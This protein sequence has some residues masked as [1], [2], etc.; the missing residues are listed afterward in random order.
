LQIRDILALA[1]LA[2]AL[3]A[4][5][6]CGARSTTIDGYGDGSD[7]DDGGTTTG[8]T[9]STST[10]S[11]NSTTWTNT[12]TTSTT[13]TN[14]V[15]PTGASCE[16]TTFDCNSCQECAINGPCSDEVYDCSDNPACSALLGCVNDCDAVCSSDPD[17]DSCFE[18]CV[19]GPGG[20]AE[21][22]G[23]GI[24]DFNAL[25]ECVLW[26]QCPTVCGG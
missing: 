13:S 16:Q 12:G 22:Y 18:T 23:D 19:N 9:G 5:A 25:V 26:E 24:Q 20:C 4:A 2:G 21:T 17:P 8:S 15:T 10:W 7:D 3:P 14:T 1:L 6:A 11:T